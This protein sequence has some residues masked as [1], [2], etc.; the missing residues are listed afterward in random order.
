[1]KDLEYCNARQRQLVTHRQSFAVYTH[2][3]SDLLA[4][5]SARC[6]TSELALGVCLPRF[7]ANS[8]SP[9][10]SKERGMITR[11]LQ[12]SDRYGGTLAP[13]FVVPL[14]DMVGKGGLYL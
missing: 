13:W 1:M 5:G 10:S 3:K 4:G 11:L 8:I 2:H 12:G 6:L 7:E 9:D 14:V